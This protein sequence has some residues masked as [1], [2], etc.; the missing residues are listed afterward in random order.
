[1]TAENKPSLHPAVKAETVER[2]AAGVTLQALAELKRLPESELR[3]YGCE[4]RTRRGRPVVAVPYRGVNGETLAIRFR[5][6]L[7]KSSQGVDDRFRWRS[8][9]KATSL[10]G[11]P[12][13]GVARAAG[14]VLVV[15]GESDCWAGW[16][17]G[18]PVVGVPGKSNWKPQMAEAL[19]GLD[20]YIWQEPDAE[21]FSE[22]VGRDLPDAR[23]IVAPDGVKD[24]ADAHVAGHDLAALL[25]DLRSSAPSLEQI[26]AR[27]SAA[28]V[29]GLRAAARP[30]LDH[31]DPVALYRESLAGVGY[32]G[33]LATPLITLLALTGRVLA[34]RPGA[35]PV[36]LLLL[37]PASAGKSYALAVALAHLPESAYHVID[38]GS[39]RTLIYDDSDLRHKALVF[40]EADSLPAGEDSPAASAVRN[41][42]AD[43]RLHYEVTVR[44]PATGDFTV[45]EISKPGPTTMVTTSTRRLGPQLDS[46][47]FIL[48]V[49][50]DREQLGHALRAQASLE[51]AGAGR[52]PDPALVAY[53]EY[54]QELAPWH[55]VV[56][57]ADVVAAHLAAQPAEPRVA[58]D[59]ARLLSLVKA[60]TVLRH[61]QR[62]R[63]RDGRLVAVP[64]DYATVF[65]L[66][67]EMFRVSNTGAGAK[68]RAVVQAVADHLA[69]G[70]THASQA[71]LMRRLDLGKAAVSRRVAAAKRDGW[72]VDDETV[73]GR[74]ARL[75]IGEPLPS[76]HGL[77]TPEQVDCS[78]VS[79][80][81]GGNSRDTFSEP[82]TVDVVAEPAARV[83]AP[84]H[85]TRIPVIREAADIVVAVGAASLPLLRSRL[86]LREAE[87]EQVLR[88]LEAAGI[89]GPNGN[90]ARAVLVEQA[91]AQRLIDAHLEPEPVA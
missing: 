28:R 61:A 91:E 79:P 21:D 58:R 47:L 41:L 77:P 42:L 16:H 74:P 43:H 19:T 55:V 73:K 14:W 33:D 80:F 70:H 18:L 68:I 34:M 89:V 40:A 29:P 45:R 50:D 8:G 86:G 63:D 49:P 81:P 26:R 10:Y 65:H 51:L 85:G 88:L 75:R 67:A 78:A 59:Y 6:A 38:A 72:L 31:P 90:K 64:A 20:V 57:F 71:D 15:E 46:R 56:P 7:A 22:R 13:L 17:H 76:D 83:P 82:L 48:E 62:A 69:S 39:P 4:Q 53:Q 23:V 35:M 84:D 27:R 25:A 37:G 12:R 3:E 60:V 30:V 2:S 52:E 5:T 87:A 44:D 54:I 66:T 11:L 9:D 32:G 36:H 24:I 1:M